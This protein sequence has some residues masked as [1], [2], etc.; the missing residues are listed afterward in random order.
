MDILLFNKTK[1]SQFLM[2]LLFDNKKFTDLITDF[3]DFVNAYIADFDKPNHDNKVI[4]VFNTKQKS[5]P[6]TNQIDKYTKEIKDG[7]V[8][9]FFYVYDLPTQY[10]DDYAMWLLGKYSMLS[11]KAKQQILNF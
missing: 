7:E 11:D 1:A 9:H 3:K 2:P 10:E 8:T 4:L 6:E 5:L